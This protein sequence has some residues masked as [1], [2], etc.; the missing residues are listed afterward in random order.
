M[1]N[2]YRKLLAVLCCIGLGWPAQMLAVAF[3]SSTADAPKWFRI[4][5]PNRESR[6]LTSAGTATYL[7]GAATVSYTDSQLWRVEQRSDGTYNLVCRSGGVYIDPN[8]TQ[9]VDYNPAYYPVSSEPQTGW[10]IK[11]ISGQ[12]DLYIIVSGTKQLHQGATGDQYRV[13]SYGGGSNTT[14]PGCQFRFE[15]FDPTDPMAVPRKE[16]ETY[17]ETLTSEGTNPGQYTAQARQTYREAIAAANT[18][19]EL[20]AARQAYDAT[21]LPVVA[22]ST[23]YIVSGP[24]AAYCEGKVI[25]SPGQG[26]QPKFGDR[27]ASASYVWTFEDAGDQKFYIRNVATG[28]Y[29]NAPNATTAQP[30]TAYAV[31]SLGQQAAFTIQSTGQ[32]PVHAQQNGSVIVTW[33]GGLNTASAWHFETLSEADLNTPVSIQS[34]SAVQGFLT[35]APGNTDRI[36]LR[37]DLQTGG[38]QGSTSVSGLT[39]DLSGSTDAAADLASVKIYRSTSNLFYGTQKAQATLLDSVAVSG[40]TVQLQFSEPQKLDA[41]TT[42]FFVTTDLKPSATPDHEVDATLKS[43]DLPDSTMTI[44]S[45]P[46]GK[47]RIFKSHTMLFNPYDDGSHYWRIPAMLVLHHQK[48]SQL[49]GRIVTITDKRYNSN[50]DLPNYIDLITRHSDDNGQTWSEDKLIAGDPAVSPDYGYGDAALVE[51]AHGRVICLMAADKQFPG[52]SYNSPIRYYM[53]YSDDAGQTWSKPQDL[54][55]QIYGQKYTQGQLQGGFTTSGRGIL[56]QRQQD[57]TR[58]GRVMFAMACKFSTGNYQNYTLYSDDEGKTWKVSATSAYDG[59]NEAKVA[60]LPDGTIMLSTRRSGNRGFNLSTDGGETWG[61]Q[62]EN[63]QIWGASCNADILVYSDDIILHTICNSGSRQNVTL[64]ASIDGGQTYPYKKVICELG[65]AYSTIDR[66]ANGDVAVYYEDNSMGDD[67]YSMNFVTLPISW[68]VSGNPGLENFKN[69]VSQARQMAE[70]GTYETANVSTA[71]AGEY[72]KSAID[73]L[74][75]VIPSD[76]EIEQM[77][78]YTE[79]TRAIEAAMEAARATCIA[80]DGYAPDTYFTISS[81]DHIGTTDA[82]FFLSGDGKAYAESHALAQKWLIRA[83]DTQGRVTLQN[84]DNLRYLYRSGNT[85]ALQTQPAEWGLEKNGTYYLLHAYTGK[86]GYVVINKGT[87]ALDFWNSAS[88]NDTWRT[89]FVLTASGSVEDGIS[90]TLQTDGIRVSQKAIYADGPAR[91][92]SLSGQQVPLG[93]PLPTGVY[94]VKTGQKACHVLI[95]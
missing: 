82:P 78:S 87:G 70:A 4:Y 13:I 7:S 2:I 86:N 85:V 39:I 34:A 23:Y 47:A 43:I 27:Q 49:N 8:H 93:Q 30:Q 41:G 74:L 68:L 56:L 31:T 90:Q 35:M 79:A 88:G 9:V 92:Y 71:K 80:V 20:N 42:H 62:Y 24:S 45:N 77:S 40:N 17:L 32:N 38:F 3:E 6:T 60:E 5:T 66:L 50:G 46:K 61:Q 57:T 37:A 53:T 89:A 22:G 81:V 29:L 10:Q 69:L 58:N 11:A 73:A 54:T 65:S 28:E 33:A 48:N 19:A 63:S 25:Y 1:H 94:I 75:K 55:T 91:A 95:K 14:D 64:Y 21:R 84:A 18:T 26:T 15:S 83:A 72:E 67:A 44:N 52:S 12:T 51:T 76:E 59:G 36:L 16:A